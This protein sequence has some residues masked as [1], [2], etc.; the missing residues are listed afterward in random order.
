MKELKE[1][2]KRL[3]EL[4]VYYKQQRK[5]VNFKGIRPEV[6]PHS[7]FQS[8]IAVRNTYYTMSQKAQVLHAENR[9]IL[10]YLY[11]T[12]YI[13]K[14]RHID[15]IPYRYNSHYD[16]ETV[17]NYVKFYSTQDEEVIHNS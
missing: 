12:L 11:C 16:K 14:G 17:N 6:L 15:T 4:Q 13:L 2:I 1:E 3:A 5:T 7:K 8:N 10:R 9:N